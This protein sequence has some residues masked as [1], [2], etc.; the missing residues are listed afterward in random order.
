MKLINLPK[1][2]NYQLKQI[3]LKE[4]V[5]KFPDKVVKVMDREKDTVLYLSTMRIIFQK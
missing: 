1:E 4:I 5:D 3:S 2:Q